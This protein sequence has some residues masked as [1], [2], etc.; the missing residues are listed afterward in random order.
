MDKAAPLALSSIRT[1]LVYQ[2]LMHDTDRIITLAESISGDRAKAVWW[3]SQPLATFG[4]KTL[5][6][7]IA[8]GGPKA[9]NGIRDYI[10][11][12]ACALGVLLGV[13]PRMTPLNGFR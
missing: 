10:K 8:E 5:F 9:A 12:S 2:P 7:L 11:P 1:Y 4:G 13:Y 3:L 6:R